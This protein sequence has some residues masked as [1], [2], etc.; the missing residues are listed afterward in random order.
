[1]AEKTPLDAITEAVEKYDSLLRQ[2]PD[3]EKVDAMLSTAG[4]KGDD[5]EA[6]MSK[7]EV[8]A[9]KGYVPRALDGPEFFGM[10]DLQ[11][12]MKAH[13]AGMPMLLF[14]PPGTGKTSMVRAALPDCVVMEGTSET[15]TADFVGS[16]VQRT[17]GSFEWVDG[18][19]VQ[20][21]DQGKALC[22]NEIALIDPRALAVL[23]S[24]M[25]GQD[26]LHV[27]SNPDRGTVKAKPGFLV[28]GTC[29]PDAPGAIMSEA[30]LSRFQIHLEVKT[31]WTLAKELGVGAKII[32]VS[33]N[34]EKRKLANEIIA[35][36]QLREMLTFRDTTMVFGEVVALRN[37][38]T[39]A[40]E[41]DREI[42]ADVAGDVFGRKI[43]TLAV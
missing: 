18:P 12:V 39:Q 36:P 28:Y 26:E 43:Q 13:E 32:T 30:L 25:D 6:V 34:L 21:L 29:N 41:T 33:R 35:S 22:V 8:V 27:T 38:V 14:G 9:P 15:E 23:Y 31:D 2:K 17:D 7:P 42:Y 5:A 20:A 11:F 16:Y 3:M 37:F 19:L 10:N 24:V 4:M 1:M 40:R